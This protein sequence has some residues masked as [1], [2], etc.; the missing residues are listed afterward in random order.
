[1]GRD[2]DI[3]VDERLADVLAESVIVIVLVALHDL[4]RDGFESLRVLRHAVRGRDLLFECTS[5]RL[6]RRVH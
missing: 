3:A 4:A 2:V 5:A 1:M 6:G